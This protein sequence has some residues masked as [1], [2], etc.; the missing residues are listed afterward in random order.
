MADR[1]FE[2]D[3]K[4]SSVLGAAAIGMEK[5]LGRL[6]ADLLLERKLRIEKD[7]T[8]SADHPPEENPADKKSPAARPDPRRE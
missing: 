2:E 5:P 6:E 7:A 3:T 1:E 8:P 4:K